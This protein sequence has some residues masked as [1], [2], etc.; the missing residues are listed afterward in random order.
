MS[1]PRTEHWKVLGR[2]IGY[3]KGKNTKG[4][5]VRNT[6]VL[7]AVMFYDPNYATNNE[8]RKCVKSIVNILGGAL[9]KFSSKTQ[10]TLH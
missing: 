6:K 8:T 7:K 10:R 9:L 3:L 2:L 1:H 5:I 4:I